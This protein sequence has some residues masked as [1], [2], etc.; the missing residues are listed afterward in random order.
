MKN[1]RTWAWIILGIYLLGI[2]CGVYAI[3][4]GANA[5]GTT[6]LILI[7]LGIAGTFVLRRDQKKEMERQEQQEKAEPDGGQ[8]QPDS[9]SSADGG[10]SNQNTENPNGE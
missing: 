4:S 8:S 2:F 3:V 5:L 7:L 1:R 9:Q 10:K 6:A